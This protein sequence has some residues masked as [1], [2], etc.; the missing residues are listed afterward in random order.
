M[1]WPPM[2][3]WMAMAAWLN[4]LHSCVHVLLVSFEE[5]WLGVGDPE[6]I[7]DD[8]VGDEVNEDAGELEFDKE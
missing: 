1:M 2:G 6:D 3:A 8:G 5:M 7:G 4:V